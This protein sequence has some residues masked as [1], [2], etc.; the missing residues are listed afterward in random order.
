M[1]HVWSLFSVLYLNISSGIEST[2][3]RLVVSASTNCTTQCPYHQCTHDNSVILGLLWNALHST[4]SNYLLV[5]HGLLSLYYSAAYNPWRRKLSVI[6][7][8]VTY[9]HPTAFNPQKMNVI[10][11]GK[12]SDTSSLSCCL[13][14]YILPAH[15]ELPQNQKRFPLA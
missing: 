13:L 1:Q 3:F 10:E 11:G 2:A 12:D 9:P 4:S 7:E 8:S 5:I 15:F 6:Y 14:F